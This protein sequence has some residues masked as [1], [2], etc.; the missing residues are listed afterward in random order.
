[1][2]ASGSVGSAVR[3]TFVGSGF[4]RTFVGS[5]FSRT[6]LQ[7]IDLR[8]VWVIERGEQLRLALEP[9]QALGIRR[10]HLGQDLQG[11]VAPEARIAG[12]IHLA[13]AAGTDRTD[14]FID[15]EPLPRH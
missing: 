11:D 14:H 5:G 12:A 6:F 9:R 4:S 13:H 1:M 10:E 8:N 2:T 15:A 3:R 7:P